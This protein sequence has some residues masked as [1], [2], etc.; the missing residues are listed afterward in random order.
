MSEF[1][2]EIEQNTS[3]MVEQIQKLQERLDHHE[4][5]L[6]RKWQANSELSK[7]L[8]ELESYIETDKLHNDWHHKILDIQ[9]NI[10]A[11]HNEVFSTQLNR[12]DTL[13]ESYQGLF[14]EISQLDKTI[15]Q[16]VDKIFELGNFYYKEKK[17]PHKC[18]ICHGNGKELS[19]IAQQVSICNPCEGKGIVWG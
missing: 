12:I 17:A 1:H 16:L 11:I 7:R 5:T 13:E 10:K 6:N 15:N 19:L 8:S 9:E 14:H 3:P 4:K 2:P 18:P